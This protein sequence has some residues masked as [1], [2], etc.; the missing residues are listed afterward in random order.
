MGD[1]GG[2]EVGVTGALSWV[3]H[4]SGVGSARVHP[5]FYDFAVAVEKLVEFHF[6]EVLDTEIVGG[7]GVFTAEGEPRAAN[8]LKS[9]AFD[10]GA[11][12]MQDLDSRI[13]FGFEGG[14]GA[15]G[16][17]FERDAFAGFCGEPVKVYIARFIHVSTDGSRYRNFCDGLVSGRVVGFVFFRS[18]IF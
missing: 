1:C 12:C 10:G 14:S 3:D 18:R 6:A 13:E 9:R 8:G 16:V 11:V 5:E 4:E 7:V 2:V 15:R 17:D